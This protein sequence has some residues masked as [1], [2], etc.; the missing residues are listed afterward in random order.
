[1]IGAEVHYLWGPGTV[2][3]HK[4]AGH[5]GSFRPILIHVDFS[6]LYYFINAK[7]DVI[8]VLFEHRIEFG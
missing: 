4:S 5:G 2:S 6:F 3:N 1:M 7:A 8:V